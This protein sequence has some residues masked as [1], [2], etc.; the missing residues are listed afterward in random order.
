MKQEVRLRSL[1][2]RNYKNEQFPD[3][4]SS[5]NNILENINRLILEGQLEDV[6]KYNF[7]VNKRHLVNRKDSMKLNREALVALVKARSQLPSSDY[8][9]IILYGFRSLKEQTELVKTVEKELKKT[10]PDN[11]EE[12]LNQYT[13][14]Y[15]D[16]KEKN[17]SNMNHR[18]GNSV[19]LTLSFKGKEVNM[20]FDSNGNA[21]M[22]KSDE[23]DFYKTGTIAENR[24][25]L[26]TVMINNGFKNYPKEWWHWGYVR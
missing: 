18:S 10:N 25:I 23:I 6:T 26:K 1:V 22:D 3:E 8:N 2:Y 11:W 13:G 5:R 14:G 12:L 17:I 20:G 21:K 4:S 9:F 7:L 15:S 19:D 24:N 16:L